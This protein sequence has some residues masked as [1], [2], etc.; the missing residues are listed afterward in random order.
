M[1]AFFLGSL[2]SGLQ[3]ADIVQC[4]EDTDDIDTVCDGLLYEVFYYICLLYTSISALTTFRSFWMK[5]LVSVGSNFTELQAVRPRLS[6]AA[7]TPAI[8]RFPHFIK[9]N[10]LL[11]EYKQ[12]ILFYLKTIDISR[13]I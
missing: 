8:K 2:H 1:A 12:F 10:L 6:T 4:I 9:K 11:T 7:K 13:G 3:V 5:I